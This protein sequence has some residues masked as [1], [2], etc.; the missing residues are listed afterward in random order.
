MRV[1][2]L[3]WVLSLAACAAPTDVGAPPPRRLPPRL[4]LGR[5]GALV[6]GE[7]PQGPWLHPTTPQEWP[8]FL[9]LRRPVVGVRTD[10]P[11]SLASAWASLDR[12]GHVECMVVEYGSQ[13]GYQSLRDVLRQRLGPPTVDSSD[14]MGKFSI[15][16][17]PYSVWWVGA[18]QR[19]EDRGGAIVT[20]F[21]RKS[22]QDPRAPG[23][24]P[25]CTPVPP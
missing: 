2:F 21:A 8:P 19:S 15:W 9:Y 16:I 18:G 24:T 17:D 1:P 14:A 23:F 6:L 7:P 12:S 5:Y 22:R 3:F 20:A 25:P 10:T 11:D 4:D 13:F